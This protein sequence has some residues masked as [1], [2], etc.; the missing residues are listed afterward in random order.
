MRP[1]FDRA[2]VQGILAILI[3]VGVFLLVGFGKEGRVP[4]EALFGLAGAVVGYYFGSS[5]ARPSSQA[6]DD[7]HEKRGDA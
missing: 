7:D 5:A 2:T 3:V 6:D 1:N 4:M